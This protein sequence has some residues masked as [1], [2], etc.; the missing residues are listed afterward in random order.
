VD[1]VPG[2]PAPPGGSG[3]E[4][5]RGHEGAAPLPRAGRGAARRAALPLDPRVAR[6]GAHRGERRGAGG[7]G[8]LAHHGG[9]R[10]P[11]GFAEAAPGAQGGHPQAPRAGYRRAGRN[12]RR[13]CF[14]GERC[15]L[16]GAAVRCAAAGRDVHR[17]E[18]PLRV[19]LTTC[20]TP[21][22]R[23]AAESPRISLLAPG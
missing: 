22:P 23:R 20:S 11:G 2:G 7:P 3:R 14:S 4:A 12:G 10:P 1:L 19:E 16:S 8:G 18:F 13:G 15:L 6:P 9:G 21:T 5:H 17:T